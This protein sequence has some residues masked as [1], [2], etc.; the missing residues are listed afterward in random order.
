MFLCLL[1]LAIPRNSRDENSSEVCNEKK[2][3]QDDDD[4]KMQQTYKVL[5]WLI[6]GLEDAAV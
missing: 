2:D 1:R 4:D 6:W 5:I 3:A